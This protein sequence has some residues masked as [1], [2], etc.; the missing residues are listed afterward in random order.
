[1]IENDIG[2]VD[3]IPNK[4]KTTDIGI[5]PSEWEVVELGAIGKII[6]GL[7][8]SPE[9]IHEDGIL[10]LRSSNI[11]DRR[12]VFTDNV[13]VKSDNFTAVQ[14]GDILI[15]VRNG[16]KSLIGKNAL[17]TEAADG[18][19]F[20]AF[21]AIFRS[22]NNDYLYQVFNTNF[23]L[24]EIHKNLGATI[25]S[26]NGSDLKKFKI[27]LPPLSERIKIAKILATW[28]IAIDNSKSIINYL[29]ERN[30][31][32]IQK[33]LTGKMRVNRFANDKWIFVSIRDI[34]KEISRKNS[35]NKKLIVLSCT[36]HNGLVPSLEYFGRKIY[37][38]NLITYKIVSKG[39]F[40]Y[41]TNHIEEGSIGYQSRYDEALIS[42]MYTVFD[43]SDEINNDFLFKVL[44]SKAYIHQYQKR[45]EGS[46][47]RRGG[48]RW[49]EFSKIKIP[50]PS[51]TEQVAINSILSAAINEL[52]EYE[53]KLKKLQLQKKGLMQQLLTGKTRVKL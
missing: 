24:K 3:E 25:N 51:M 35:T 44:K 4:Y 41:A 36:K 2:E 20:G 33:L 9:D 18:M 1:M 11:K 8:Y 28:D 16:S 53:R 7:T 40:A 14:K 27:P 37:S 26:I 47:D 49:N 52:H 31:G 48:L 6:S 50:F 34:A 39:H 30:T 22:D 46:I 10:V 32:L 21:M 5:I 13:Y 42:P 17:I 45:M 29:I 23:Y 38:D 19:A 43:T 15:C 12:I